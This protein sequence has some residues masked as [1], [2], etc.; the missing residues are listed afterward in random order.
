[1]FLFFFQF[2]S[3][4]LNVH[5]VQA[6]IHR[7]EPQ[8]KHGRWTTWPPSPRRRRPVYASDTEIMFKNDSPVAVPVEC[9]RKQRQLE[10]PVPRRWVATRIR[11]SQTSNAGRRPGL[12]TATYLCEHAPAWRDEIFLWPYFIYNHQR[13]QRWEAQ[14]LAQLL[15]WTGLVALSSSFMFFI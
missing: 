13:T 5:G 8:S 6:V 11:R 15:N 2:R 7:Y 9:D 1:M 14:Q 3:P 10:S 4:Y 12:L